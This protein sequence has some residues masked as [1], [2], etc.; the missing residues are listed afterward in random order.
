MLGLFARSKPLST[1]EI[2][3]LEK[4]ISEFRKIRYILEVEGKIC[5]LDPEFSTSGN[6]RKAVHRLKRDYNSEIYKEECNCDFKAKGKLN[7]DGTPRKHY[8]YLKDW[9]I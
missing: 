7:K 1:V 3:Y 8:A 2:L 5:S 6:L 9:A 4:D